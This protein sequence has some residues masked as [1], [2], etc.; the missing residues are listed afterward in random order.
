MKLNLNQTQFFATVNGYKT[1]PNKKPKFKNQTEP[2]T[3]NSKTVQALVCSTMKAYYISAFSFLLYLTA[4]KQPNL[5][6]L[7]E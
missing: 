6:L 2:K 3:E 7:E 5:G 1:E 4:T